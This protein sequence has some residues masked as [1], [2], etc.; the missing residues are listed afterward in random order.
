MVVERAN[1]RHPS[2]TPADFPPRDGRWRTSATT[3]PKNGCSLPIH[4]HRIHLGLKI[5]LTALLLELFLELLD[6]LGSLRFLPGV[7]PLTV[8]VMV[9]DRQSGG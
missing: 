3:A 1:G 2:R 5:A 9:A 6:S 4:R 7:R 8:L